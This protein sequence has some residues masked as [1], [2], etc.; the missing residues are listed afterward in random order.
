M[1]FLDSLIQEC[2]KND[3]SLNQE[4]AQE[5]YKTIYNIYGNDI[6]AID[7][8]HDIK[9]WNR[10]IS[11]DDYGIV[12]IETKNRIIKR[13]LEIIKKTFSIIP[14]HLTDNY[15]GIYGTGTYADQFIEML[16]E[17]PCKIRAKLIFIDSHIKT[18]K[19]T[20]RDF[21]IINIEDIES[22][23]LNCIVVASA[24]Y[25]HEIC[26]IIKER[27]DNKFHVIRLIT[28]LQF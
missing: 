16:K 22:L 23:S 2:Q 12:P 3:L 24:K 7:T 27:Y 20:Y 26:K 14:L 25:E 6:E 21:N 1:N 8:Y 19:Q 28:D 17:Y 4:F 9:V 15:I 10:M 5:I 11:I 18:G 13:K